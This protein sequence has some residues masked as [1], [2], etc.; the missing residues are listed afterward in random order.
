[1][2]IQIA[3]GTHDINPK[4]LY[5][6]LPNTYTVYKYTPEIRNCSENILNLCILSCYFLL[7]LHISI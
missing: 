3:K 7:L 2:Y 5:I 4:P 1:M 6:C